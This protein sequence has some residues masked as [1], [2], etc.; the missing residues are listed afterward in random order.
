MKTVIAVFLFM[1]AN[2][3]L[4]NCSYNGQMYPVGTQLG[5]LT[6]TAQGWK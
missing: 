3:A 4:A 1:V 2:V 6:C 5:G